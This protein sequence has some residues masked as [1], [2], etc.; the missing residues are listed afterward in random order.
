M[1]KLRP[2]LALAL[3]A[4]L[5]GGFL[6]LDLARAAEP[7]ATINFFYSE[8]CPHCHDE[9]IFLDG[10]EELYGDRLRINRYS[11]NKI[12]TAGILKNLAEEYEATDVFG[13]VPVTFVGKDYYVGF[14]SADGI[15]RKITG[16]M[17]AQ[18]VPAESVPGPDPEPVQPGEENAIQ[19]PFLGKIVPSH[20]SLP[21]LAVFLGVLDGMNVC[22]LGA[23]VLILGLTLELKSRKRILFYGILFLLTTA[24]VYGMLINLWS[25]LFSVLQNYLGILG[26]LI[27][28][29]GIV[30]GLFFFKEF[31]RMRK[32]G[33]ICKTTG[34]SFVDKAMKMA[35]AAF[36]K[37]N[38][39]FYLALAV[40]LFAAVVVVVEFP[41]SAAVPVAFAGIMADAGVS[42]G[43]QFFLLSLYLL[44]YLLDELLIFGIAAWQM[45]V[46]LTSP[47]FTI[48]ATFIES[49]F[50]FA[51]GLYYL[52]GL[53]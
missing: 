35:E 17:L 42:G 1:H 13:R 10:L 12:G 53:I 4:F 14:D 9:S 52:A 22:S 33:L 8:T 27:G 6:N 50:L 24:I 40:A 30:G 37:P 20:Y 11:I 47:N 48:W 36:S 21:A 18:L 32:V 34:A 7:R 45:K 5:L 51:L 39:I 31:L 19:V 26:L 2:L 44:F 38:Q 49:V 3:P 25:Q 41:C 15:G 29:L 23:L 43:G 16:S 28:V 46:V